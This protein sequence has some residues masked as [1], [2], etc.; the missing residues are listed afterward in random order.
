MRLLFP[1]RAVVETIERTVVRQ[2]TQYIKFDNYRL[3]VCTFNIIVVILIIIF[4]V[5]YLAF[6]VRNIRSSVY[7]R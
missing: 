5:S 3:R 1:K 6:L 2:R 4:A 7:A